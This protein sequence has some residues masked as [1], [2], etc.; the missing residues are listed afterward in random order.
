MAE[1]VMC[2]YDCE[3]CG[4]TYQDELYPDDPSDCC[5][6]PEC[7][8]DIVCPFCH[9]KDFDKAGLKKHLSVDCKVYESIKLPADMFEGSLLFEA[10]R[11]KGGK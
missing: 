5:Y 6:C 2:T 11:F 4:K 7:R 3:Q 9:E 8:A 1:K 10:L